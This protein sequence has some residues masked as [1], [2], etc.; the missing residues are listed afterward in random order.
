MRKFHPYFLLF[1]A[2]SLLAITAAANAAEPAPQPEKKAAAK[3]AT[4]DWSKADA[5]MLKH[6]EK[7]K[8]K[9]RIEVLSSMLLR[10]YL[11]DYRV[12][13]QSGERVRTVADI[14]LVNQ[15]GEITP[16][17]EVGWTGRGGDKFSRSPSIAE[18]LKQQKFHVKNA[19]D[20][21]EVASLFE[22]LAGAGQYLRDLE[23]DIKNLKP[24]DQA[25]LVTEYEPGQNWTFHVEEL[26]QGW[27]LK[28][29]VVHA[30]PLASAP[31]PPKYRMDLDKQ[32]LFQ[33][34]RQENVIPSIFLK[35]GVK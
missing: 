20:A 25:F 10:K 3:V 15:R 9:M 23:N 18:F 26:D 30:D 4:V 27:Q 22:E 13:V 29:S 19:D 21:V 12:Y 35:N 32:Q 8:E 17:R 16:L 28:K 11:P 33:D 14:F 2:V 24:A 31:E 34:L 7:I 1:W 6:L 5:A